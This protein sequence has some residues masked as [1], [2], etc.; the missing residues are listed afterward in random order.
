MK[1]IFNGEEYFGP[2]GPAGPDGTPIGS[3]ISYL[4]RTAPRDYLT[5]DGG[6]Y[7]ISDY[8]ELAAFFQ[9]EFGSANHFGGDGES[10]FAV[11]DMRQAGS[12]MLHCIKAVESFQAQDV[13][14]MEERRIGTWIDGK[15]LYRK[16]FVGVAPNA[17]NGAEISVIS[18]LSLGTI[19]NGYGW[20]DT[21]TSDGAMYIPY[22]IDTSNVCYVYI[23]ND[24]NG[25]MILTRGSSFIGKNFWY[26]IEYTKATDPTTIEPSAATQGGASL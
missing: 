2:R 10:T 1:L 17:P 12:T 13:Y 6:E 15:P 4:G 24:K 26:T 18:A 7:S 9:K 16:T 14:S 25:L 23:S 21:N 11:P 19:A 3:I 5:C 8:P 22:T 20:I